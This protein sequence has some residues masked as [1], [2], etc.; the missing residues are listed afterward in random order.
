MDVERNAAKLLL[1]RLNEPESLRENPL[2]ASFASCSD[3]ERRAAVLRA[4]DRLDPGVL[5]GAQAERRRRKHA[6]VLR[7]DVYG[8]PQAHVARD[9]GL[10]MRQFFRERGE[11]FEEFIGALEVKPPAPRAQPA[12]TDVFAVRER[13]I[14]KLRGCG[15]HE[16]VWM[17]A[18]GFASELGESERAIEFWSVA[19]EGARYMGDL[20]RSAKAIA[21]AQRVREVGNIA[22]PVSADILITI[23]QIALDWTRGRYVDAAERLQAT[24]QRHGYGRALMDLDATL[25]GIMLTYGVPIEIERGRWEQARTLLRHLEDIGGRIDKQHTLTS[26]RRHAGRVALRGQ[27]DDDRAIVE[28][29]E[30]LAVAQRFDNFAAEASAA[31]D[32][33]IA[34][35]ARDSAA[36]GEYITYG[37]AA[38]RRILGRNEFAMLALGALPAIWLCFG[39]GEASVRLEEIAASGP[40]AD[41]AQFAFDLAEIA[42]MLARREYRAVLERAQPLAQT[43]E[44]RGLIAPAGEATLM[45]AS[46]HVANGRHSVAR[47][48]L[49]EC[50][51]LV[52]ACG[53]TAAA[54]SGVIGSNLAVA[55][56]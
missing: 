53:E 54:W 20:E 52:R 48:L 26:L 36:A 3:D 16:R 38:G 22:R 44:R 27:N 23:P 25:F 32:L 50:T 49:R 10:S 43:L 9:L 34:L 21:M 7:C 12:L 2:L 40:L 42:L 41:R 8:E 4:V 33:G 14:Q 18:S 31:T 1:R 19:A 45:A 6:I 11:A 17:E 37:L 5:S 39:S 30:A 28:L 13:F 46:A 47:R 15:Q 29:R 55:G 56:H 35:A 24:I 51:D